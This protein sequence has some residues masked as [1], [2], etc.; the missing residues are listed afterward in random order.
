MSS[1][2]I[3]TD[4]SRHNLQTPSQDL[5]QTSPAVE[6]NERRSD[7]KQASEEIKSN[8]YFERPDRDSIELLHNTELDTVQA[9]RVQDSTSQQQTVTAMAGQ[10]IEQQLYSLTDGGD[11]NT[12]EEMLSYA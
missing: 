2:H 5:N 9:S 11:K 10:N 4:H 1:H 8:N 7:Q 3:E 12:D 6:A